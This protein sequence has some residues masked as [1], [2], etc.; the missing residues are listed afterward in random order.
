MVLIPSQESETDFFSLWYVNHKKTLFFKCLTT[1]NF[2]MLVLV[3]FNVFKQ[4]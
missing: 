1:V 2:D 4:T 3:H